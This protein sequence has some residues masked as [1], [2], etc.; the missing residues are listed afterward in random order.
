MSDK[1]LKQ[2]V[3]GDDLADEFGD[4][5]LGNLGF[6]LA[7]FEVDQKDSKE[8]QNEEKSSEKIEESPKN[9][10][11]KNRLGKK[12]LH[13]LKPPD[14]NENPKP[15]HISNKEDFSN[16]NKI[17]KISKISENSNKEIF[18]NNKIPQEKDLDL[19]LICIH[20]GEKIYKL[21][22]LFI[23]KDQKIIKKIERYNNKIMSISEK[24]KYEKE[25]D[26]QK[27]DISESDEI[28]QIIKKAKR[29]QKF[30]KINIT[31]DE[32]FFD[33]THFLENIHASTLAS[34]EMYLLENK[35]QI[36]K[37][38]LQEGLLKS[39]GILEEKKIDDILIERNLL[40]YLNL[41]E[42]KLRMN[43][44]KFPLLSMGI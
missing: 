41:K 32:K 22:D 29:N 12:K 42:S 10:N 7:D 40:N 27:K 39:F 30:T 36:K 4:F 9:Q 14:D 16:T 2:L 24:E 18:Q 25:N 23:P 17:S 19:K 6:C 44:R 5:N 26:G 37:K 1:I 11:K 28:K 38:I 43:P 20:D 15:N 21:S 35:E 33:R 13:F 34:Q 8:S 3:L 31:Y